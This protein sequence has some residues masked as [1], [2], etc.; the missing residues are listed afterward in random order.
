MLMHRQKE[1]IYNIAKELL[2][3]S[4]KEFYIQRALH[5]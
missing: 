4:L 3:Q 5:D 1:N 2:Q